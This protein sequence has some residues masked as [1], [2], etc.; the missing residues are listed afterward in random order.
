MQTQR[1]SKLHFAIFNLSG[2]DKQ[3]ERCHASPLNIFAETFQIVITL[4]EG[5]ANFKCLFQVS[6]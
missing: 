2:L 4:H 3:S 5:N 1:D 6:C